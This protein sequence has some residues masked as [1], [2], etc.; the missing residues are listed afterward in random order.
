MNWCANGLDCDNG[1]VEPIFLENVDVCLDLNVIR[2]VL[3]SGVVCN[4]INE[5]MKMNC[6]R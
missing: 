5:I 6:V 2:G 3:P 1:T 4:R